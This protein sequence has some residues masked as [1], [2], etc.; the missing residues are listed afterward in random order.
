MFKIDHAK[1]LRKLSVFVLRRITRVQIRNCRQLK[2]DISSDLAQ[3]N[4]WI[5]GFLADGADITDTCKS[6]GSAVK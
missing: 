6:L 5:G 3:L 2:T 1:I 4:G